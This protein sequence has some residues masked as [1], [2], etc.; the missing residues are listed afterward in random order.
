MC[1]TELPPALPKLN[2]VLEKLIAP[3][4]RTTVVCG[5]SANPGTQ[6]GGGCV[7]IECAQGCAL[8]FETCNVTANVT[9]CERSVLQVK[10][11][12]Q[13]SVKMRNVRQLLSFVYSGE[14]HPAPSRE[15]RVALKRM[16]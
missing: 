16:S 3:Y 7:P 4:R 5:A 10:F 9:K 13:S 6:A 14:I 1:R 11:G 12:L 2:I 8:L 15:D